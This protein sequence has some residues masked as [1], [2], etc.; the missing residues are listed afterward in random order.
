M[1]KGL[2]VAGLLACVLAMG[3]C[4]KAYRITDA[5]D[6]SEFYYTKK[7]DKQPSGVVSFVDAQTNSQ[8]VLDR[9]HIEEITKKDMEK[10][11]K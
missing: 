8:I 4:K 6:T 2:I 11:L 10:A 9:P 3:G 5:H 1:R 7:Y